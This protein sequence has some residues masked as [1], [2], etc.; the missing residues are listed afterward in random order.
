MLGRSGPTGLPVSTN[1]C[2][3]WGLDALAR[4]QAGWALPRMLDALDDPF[5]VNRQFATRAIENWLKLS[6]NDLGYR[7]YMTAE[8]RQPV[9]RRLKLMIVPPP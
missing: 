9:I 3:W 1:R 5:L 2:D 7:F 4:S 6:L 8:Q